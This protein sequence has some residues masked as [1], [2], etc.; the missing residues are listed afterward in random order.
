[1]PFKVDKKYI[2]FNFVLGLHLQANRLCRR[3]K[4]S[5]MQ[6]L[7]R[8]RRCEKN[9]IMPYE[10][11]S[12]KPKMISFTKGTKDASCMAQPAAWNP[13]EGVFIVKI[14]SVSFGLGQ[15]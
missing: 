3:P 7:S 12:S 6:G 8:M 13:L 9:L 2:T 5:R 11:N 15:D 14:A 1:M 4:L 10:K